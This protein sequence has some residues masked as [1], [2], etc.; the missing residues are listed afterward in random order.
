MKKNFY[1]L[2]CFL[3][4]YFFS[5]HKKGHGIHSPFVFNLINEVFNDHSQYKEYHIIEQLRKQ[6][7]KSQETIST[8][9]Y[10]SLSSNEQKLFKIADLVKKSSV[11]TRYGR[12]LFRLVRYFKPENIVELGTNIGIST[13]YLAKACPDT[14]VY[15]IE[16][17]KEKCEVAK[18]NFELLSTN[19]VE[20]ICGTFEEKLPEI[21]SK[22]SKIDFVFIDGN[23][24]YESTMNYFSL[25]TKY[26]HDNTIIV[27]DDIYW[28]KSMTRAW[29]EIQNNEKVRLSL[30]IYRMGIVFFTS[31]FLE[32]QHF[33][34][35]F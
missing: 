1:Q 21:L 20:C 28:S 24:T 16:A 7:K 5:R 3:N 32:K 26:I 6:L 17:S 4:Y 33:I 34:I 31:R 8:Q 30:D 14:K 22:L 15:T 25:L 12:L 19:N 27:F 9:I 2:R 13:L 18:K 10:G 23:H 35:R 29:L 11:T